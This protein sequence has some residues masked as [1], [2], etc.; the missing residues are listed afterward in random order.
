M[1]I[2]IISISLFTSDGGYARVT[3]SACR[4]AILVS[5]GAKMTRRIRE[6]REIKMRVERQIDVPVVR[7][8]F[9]YTFFPKAMRIDLR[10][11]GLTVEQARQELWNASCDHIVEEMQPWL[12]EGWLPDCDLGPYLLRIK[13][14]RGRP[15]QYSLL[16]MLGASLLTLGLALLWFGLWMLI[17]TPIAEAVEVRVP[18]SRPC[19]SQEE[20]DMLLEDWHEHPYSADA[21]GGQSGEEI[22]WLGAPERQRL[23][24]EHQPR[25]F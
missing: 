8:E 16:D 10:E 22:G 1:S 6:V 19:M 17:G 2:H 14:Y 4:S 3:L 24:D 20:V 25:W 11:T 5:K 12:R 23:P 15:L 13:V 21:A 18:I 7:N 9:V